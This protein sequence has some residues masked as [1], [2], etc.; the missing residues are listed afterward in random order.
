[1]SFQIVFVVID[2]ME[3]METD[4][5]ITQKGVFLPFLNILL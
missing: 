4:N 1:M 2:N 3:S 5:E